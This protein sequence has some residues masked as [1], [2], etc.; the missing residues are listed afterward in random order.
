MRNP[1][2]LALVGALLCSAAPAVAQ[3]DMSVEEIRS[4]FQ[5]QLQ[6]FSSVKTRGLGGGQD[7]GLKL[8]T[9]DDI[10][11]DDQGEQVVVTE[12]PTQDAGTETSTTTQTAAVTDTTSTDTASTTIETTTDQTGS[13][14][15]TGAT[16]T[17]TNTTVADT[18]TDTGANTDVTLAS[19]TDPNKP[20]VY[21][22]FKP[23]LQVNLHIEFGFDSAALDSSQK[24]K[25][26]KMCIV[27]QTSP[28][29]K[30]RI[31]GH[32]DTKGTDEYNERLSILRAREVARHL[33]E[34]CGIAASRME[35]IGLGE[36]F[37]IDANN[38]QADENRRV[39]FQAL[40]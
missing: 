13:D 18:S 17:T 3:D 16:I 2:I 8:I 4:A 31:V 6:A 26:E 34:E 30:I 11:T 24:P 12:T 36:R 10:K 20:L 40:S 23:E 22:Q 15:S 1:V 25:L 21:G 32:T 38:P 19:A 39:E 28:I 33:S 29:N 37:P 7:R 27:L 9:V 14:I 5:R 35:T